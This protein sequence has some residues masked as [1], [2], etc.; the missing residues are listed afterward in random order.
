MRI[1]YFLGPFHRQISFQSPVH[2]K[3][4]QKNCFDILHKFFQGPGTIFWLLLNTF[5]TTPHILYYTTCFLLCNTASTAQNPIYCT[6]LFW[7]HNWHSVY[8][9]QTPSLQPKHSSIAW[10][11][12][13]APHNTLVYCTPL[14]LL[15]TTFCTALSVPS[16]LH[17]PSTAQQCVSCTT[18]IYC[19]TLSLLHNSS[20]AQHFLYCKTLRSVFSATLNLDL[21]RDAHPSFAVKI[22]CSDEAKNFIFIFK[23]PSYSEKK[24][25]AHTTPA[26]F[27]QIPWQVTWCFMPSQPAL[28]YQIPW[29]WC[30]KA[31][32]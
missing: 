23:S 28:L 2:I 21:Q 29:T 11:F 16:L 1:K 31:G 24:T 25:L 19:T 26:K 5:C 10:H 12:C 15:H 32:S 20:T 8:C 27:V 6:T 14:S 18:L 3:Q 22:N 4:T 17:N 7:Q 9:K 13:N 30:V